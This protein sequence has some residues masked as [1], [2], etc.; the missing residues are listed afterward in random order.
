MS[1]LEIVDQDVRDRIARD[2]NHNVFV[3]ASAGT[4]KTSVVVSRIVNAIADGVVRQA[5]GLVAITFTE[6]AAAELRNRVRVELERAAVDVTRDDDERERCARARDEIDHATITTLHGFAQRILAEHP[7]A[8]GLPPRF[9]VADEVQARVRFVERW[10]AF[11]DDLFADPEAAGDLLVVHALGLQMRRLREVANLL[12]GRW[13][14]LVGVR[15]DPPPRLPIDLRSVID[16]VTDAIDAAGDRWGDPDLDDENLMVCLM[17]WAYLAGE[18]QRSLDND[19]VID[20]LRILGSVK[21]RAPGNR[22]RKEL[23][24]DAK[25]AVI[26]ALTRACDHRVDHLA[27]QRLNVTERLYPRLAQCTLD[28]AEERRRDGRLEFHDLLVHARDLVTTDVRIR[29]RLADRIDLMVIDE[30][31]DTD[32]IQVE[33]AFALAADAPAAPLPSWEETHLREGKLVVVGDPKQSIYRFRGADISLWDRAKHCFHRVERLEQNFRT[34]EPIVGWVND[35]FEQVIAGGTEGS[36]PAYELLA[37]IRPAFGPDSPVVLL[38]GASPDKAGVV[39][40]REAADLANLVAKVR[41]DR[42]QVSYRDK[43]N[44]EQRRSARYDDIAVLVPTRT[45][46][47]QIERALDNAD[48]PYRV[49]SRSLVWATDAVRDLLNI[50]AAIDDPSDDV[51]VVAAL[52]APGFACSDA[53]LVDWALAGGRW[54]LWTDVPDDLGADH[55]VAIA[56]AALLDYHRRRWE[57]RVDELVDRVIRERRLVQLTFAYRRPR[58][59]WRRIRFLA[60]QARTF[61]EGGGASLGDFLAWAAVQSDE[62]ATTVETPVPEP[63][64]DAVRILTIHGSKGLEFPIVVLAGLGTSGTDI[65]PWVRWGSTRPE[66]AVGGKERRF[67]TARFEELSAGVTEAERHEGHRLLYVAATRARDHLVVSLHHSERATQS[68]AHVLDDVCEQIGDTARWGAGDQLQLP[69][70]G[71]G[72]IAP[73]HPRLTEDEWRAWTD[74]FDALIERA[75]ERRVFSATAL[76]G[77]AH[78]AE[79]ADSAEEETPSVAPTSFRR[80]G[81]AVGRAVHAVLQ[82]IDLDDPSD[83]TAAAG[84]HAAGEDLDDAAELIARLAAS[85]LAAPVVQAAVRA[86]PSRRWREIAVAAPAGDDRMVEGFI[87]LLFEDDDGALVVVDYKTDSARTDA[88]L[89]EAVARYRVQAGTYA[90]ALGEAVGRPVARA[91]FVFCRD[92]GAVEREVVDLAE[93][94]NEARALVSATPTTG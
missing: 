5:S 30:F 13:D 55:P 19:D 92:G 36:Q 71:D 91:V 12:H 26:A 41:A 59:H 44:D 94:I 54:E 73:D 14:R 10:N 77:L 9:E 81:T 2:L 56:K 66:L 3:E 31:Q 65:G 60:D 7:L 75:N 51:A 38:G 79:P 1:V 25:G 52:R 48:I 29:T 58:D 40:E 64:D 80:G 18:L 39:R 82:T 32:P 34:V 72:A 53:E 11:C 27:A 35:V 76:A 49:E 67:Q 22:G 69:I 84:F 89:D 83:L 47:G 93:A 85:A 20:G 61:V 4:G 63:D 17:E 43:A 33:I 37:P 78:D 45:P 50:L 28:G 87:D 62:G 68:H 8:A 6:A 15:F 16:N 24:G 46:L 86:G 23:W 88:E 21:P 42:W 57:L 90:L 74:E 70:G